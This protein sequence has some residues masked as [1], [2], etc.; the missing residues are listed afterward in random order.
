M[1]RQNLI[2]LNLKLLYFDKSLLTNMKQ[3]CI[4]F[5]SGIIILILSAWGF[6]PHKLMNQNAIFTLPA[7]LSV[8]YKKHH[9]QIR[10]Y[11]INAD[12]RVYIDPAESP[13]HFIDLDRWD[14]HDS[15]QIPWNKAKEKYQEKYLIS[16]GIV[17][18]QI[19]KSYRQL[20]KAFFEKDIERI[21]KISAD[22]G[23]YVADAHVPLHTSSN[24]NGQLTDQ[25]GIH[26]LWETRLPER[27]SN[28]Y[29]LYVGPAVYID[30]VLGFAWQAVL[31]S[32]SL[33]DSVLKVEKD[34]S[35]KLP[36]VLHRSFIQRGQQLQT[37]YS[38]FYVTNY[39]N[40]LNGM[41]MRRMKKSIHAI[42]S[43]WFTA[44]VDAGQPDLA[45]TQILENKIDSI[46]LKINHIPKGREEWH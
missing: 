14:Q 43:I 20:K 46:D 24:Y 31:E 15:I 11:A 8:F 2:Y 6:K 42:G 44:W 22:L 21:I 33:L 35:N 26:A 12:K 32:H 45:N 1:F 30:D 19:E 38:D 5:I 41:V 18:W 9:Y 27:Y 4:L 40:Q 23:H 39:H 36:K 17:P 34:L 28:K 25:I 29:S 3:C 7:D 13:R 37:N 16:R 10:E